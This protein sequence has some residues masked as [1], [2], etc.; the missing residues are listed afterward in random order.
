MI[1]EKGLTVRVRGR[2]ING[3]VVQIEGPLVEVAYYEGEK[4]KKQLRVKFH[5]D[6]LVIEE[7]GN[8]TPNK[9]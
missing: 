5:K 6:Q 2:S 8:L 3:V 9:N 1:L 7:K 4:K